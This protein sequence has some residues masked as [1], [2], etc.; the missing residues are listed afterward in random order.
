MD[1]LRLFFL[2]TFFYGVF[3]QVI[4]NDVPDCRVQAGGGLLDAVERKPEDKP[5]LQLQQ[6]YNT[7]RGREVRQT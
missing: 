6:N 4:L 1:V 3:R 7:V 2:R 5:L